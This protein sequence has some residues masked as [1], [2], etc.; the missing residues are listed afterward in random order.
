MIG[1][2]DSI[3]ETSVEDYSNGSNSIFKL[4]VFILNIKYNPEQQ[5]WFCIFGY[6]VL[7]S[8]MIVCESTRCISFLIL[9]D[10]NHDPKYRILSTRV[11]TNNTQIE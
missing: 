8:K 5:M 3:H 6:V 9:V 10:I 4:I 1:P 7:K 2:N 11:V